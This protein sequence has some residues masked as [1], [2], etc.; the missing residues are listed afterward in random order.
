MILQK[1]N[2]INW[3][4]IDATRAYFHVGYIAI[5]LYRWRLKRRSTLMI[6]SAV[7]I[8]EAAGRENAMLW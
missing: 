8:E 1:V 4:S 7:R 3:K 5:P 2:T 6:T